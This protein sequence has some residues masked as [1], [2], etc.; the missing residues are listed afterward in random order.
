M[1]G[2]D[3]IELARRLDE[4]I[5]AGV[6]EEIREGR[7]GISFRFTY[8]AVREFLSSELPD[9]LRCT[10][11]QRMAAYFQ[12]FYEAGREELLTT[13]AYHYSRSMDGKM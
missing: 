6:L 7:S 13:V 3:Q 12:A 11:H 1:T 5:K 2:K 10:Y 4:C 8:G 9:S